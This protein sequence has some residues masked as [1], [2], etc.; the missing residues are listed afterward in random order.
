VPELGGVV[1][2]VSEHPYDILVRVDNP[3]PAVA[4][5]GAVDMGGSS[6]VGLNIYF[7]GD[8]A[9]SNAAR[10]LPHWQAWIHA[11]FPMQSETVQS[12]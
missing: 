11:Q 5:F 1:E 12:G 9:A 2:Y 3:A 8:Q 4:A 7:Y 10:Y 6:M